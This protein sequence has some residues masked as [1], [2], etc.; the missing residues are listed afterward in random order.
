MK[1]DK[2]LTKISAID[3]RT[4]IILEQQE[5]M[6]KDISNL[7]SKPPTC[8]LH[9]GM[10]KKIQNL[11]I[12]DARFTGELNMLDLKTKVML[13][14]GVILVSSVVSVITSKLAMMIF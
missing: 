8:P 5:E 4:L 2:I 6:R 1:S 11:R 3:E 10:E 12:S 14:S 7:K 13:G 9:E